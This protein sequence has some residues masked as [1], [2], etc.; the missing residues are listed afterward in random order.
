MKEKKTKEK[1]DNK[2]GK[3]LPTI[4]TKENNAT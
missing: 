2:K 4:S 3:L 1:T